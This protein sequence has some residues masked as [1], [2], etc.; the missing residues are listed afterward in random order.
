VTLDDLRACK[1]AALTIT[2][3]AGL[4]GLDERTVRRGVELGDLPGLKVGRRLLVPTEP[5][6]RL[7]TLTPDMRNVDPARTGPSSTGPVERVFLHATTSKFR[8]A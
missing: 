8:S 1:S 4:L 7:L 6:R 5:L 3:V 2:Q